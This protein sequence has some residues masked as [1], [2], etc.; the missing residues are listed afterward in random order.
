MVTKKTKSLNGITF[1]DLTFLRTQQDYNLIK[2]NESASLIGAIEF[3]INKSNFDNYRR[4]IA[5]FI[6][7][8]YECC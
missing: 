4:S 2:N 3:N 5:I 6:S 1:S 7:R 8:S